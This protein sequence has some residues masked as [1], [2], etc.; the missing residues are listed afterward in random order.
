VKG[1]VFLYPVGGGLGWLLV[2]GFIVPVI[3]LFV[4]FIL[5]LRG[6]SAFPMHEDSAI[7]TPDTRIPAA[8]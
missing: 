6:M 4:F 1:L 7:A 5:E 2:G 3:I 8:H